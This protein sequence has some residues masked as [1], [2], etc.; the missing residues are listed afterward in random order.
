MGRLHASSFVCPKK[1]KTWR[2][3]VFLSIQPERPKK[4]KSEDKKGMESNKIDERE[5]MR[6]LEVKTERERAKRWLR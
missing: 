5:K 1:K 2:V 3:I 6:A 4:K